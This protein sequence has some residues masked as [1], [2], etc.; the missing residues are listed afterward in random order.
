[1]GVINHN[2]DAPRPETLVTATLAFLEKHWPVLLV[3]GL[4]IRALYK[5]YASPLRKYPGPFLASFS[6]LWKVLSTASGHTHLDH[7]ALHRR[8]GPVVRIAPGEVSVSSPEAARTLLSAG[9]RFFKTPFY[10]VFPPPENP[11]IFTETREDVHATKKRVANVPYS[12]AAMQ[13]LS[14]FIDDTVELLVRKIDEFIDKNPRGVFNLGDYLHYFAFD[15]LGEVAFSRSFGF[16][17]QGKDVDGAIKT[18]DNS[19][20]YNG[21]VGQVPELDHFLRRNPLWQFVPWLSTKNAL[22]TRMALEEMARRQ[23]FDK[24]NGG[25][26][27]TGDG[28]QDLMASLIQGH[29]KDPEKFGEGDVFAVAHGAI[30]AG[31]DSTASTMQSFFWHILDAKPVYQGIVRE[32]EEA[33]KEGVIPAEGN[34]TWNQAQKL[35]YLQACLKEAMRVRPAVG[36][37]ITRLVPPEG[38]ELDGHF[39]PGGTTVACNGWVL[40]RD[41]E[42]FGQDADDFRPERWLEDE[43]RAKKME[44]YMFQFGGGSH[45]CI[46]RNLALL[47]INKVVPRLLR[48]FRIELAHPGRPLKVHASFFVVQSGLEVYIS[49]KA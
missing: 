18:I 22:I 34:L 26:L 33:V 36:L 24:D 23:P 49:R 40:H 14:P 9:R 43:E 17:E 31:S 2:A 45:L 1:M 10:G 8:Y 6:R 16:L 5:R 19:Q 48:D 27:R 4:V 25:L 12:M 13:Q 20:W 21:V 3:G 46:G 39:F 28:R 47:E 44:R 41:K 38:A 11:D 7:I 15:V 30:F 29:L 37:N 32:L 35:P 42:I